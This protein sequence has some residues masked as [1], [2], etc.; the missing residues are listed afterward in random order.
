L[1]KKLF[2]FFKI[3][4]FLS[5]G[6]LFIWLFLKDLTPGQ[7][8]DI[9]ISIKSADYRWIILSIIFGFTSHVLR[10]LRWMILMEPLGYNPKFINV[11][12]SV[13]IGYFANLALPR[14]GEVSR[15]GVLAKYEKIPFQKSFGTVV[16]E[17]AFD[18]FIFIILFLVNFAIQFKRLNVYVHDKIYLKLS[19]KFLGLF[20]PHLIWAVLILIIF[21]FGFIIYRQKSKDT[22]LYKKVKHLFV[23]FWEG[24]KSLIKIKKP[25]WFIFYTVAIWT[26]YLFMTYICFNC[27]P[28]TSGLGLN[29]GFA[30]L[31]FGSIGI[32]LVQGGIGV[33]PAIVAETLYLY[34]ISG[35]AGYALGW[36][37]W[38]NQ[39]IMIIFA[40]S[41]SL[42][43]IP[44]FNKD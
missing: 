36:I 16:T 34:A 1:K 20:N 17:R 7:K 33:Y 39:T 27:I 23:G 2:T 37:L 10:T 40:G 6:I 26:L 30:V 4:F 25:R 35:T 28:E 32:I 41:L 5:I 29:A 9:L 12:F 3:I 19:D 38:L 31:I 44:V 13:F 24:I 8:K 21:I 43:L 18:M 11:F 22:N 15:C 14:L 42:I